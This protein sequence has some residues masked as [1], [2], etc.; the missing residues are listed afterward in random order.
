MQVKDIY[1]KWAKLALLMGGEGN[2]GRH[3]GS[4]TYHIT[5]TTVPP[6]SLRTVLTSTFGTAHYSLMEISDKQNDEDVFKWTP[7]GVV[8]AL[9]LFCFAGMK[10]GSECFS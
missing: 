10:A 7:Q 8:L 9:F 2:T 6:H 5:Q 1:A 3:R 4:T